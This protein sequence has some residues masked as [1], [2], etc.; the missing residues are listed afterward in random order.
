MKTKQA[1][2]RK[3]FETTE[4]L[5]KGGLRPSERPGG[6]LWSQQNWCLLGGTAGL[7][8]PASLVTEHG[9]MTEFSPLSVSGSDATLTGTNTMLRLLGKAKPDHPTEV[10]AHQPGA[11]HYCPT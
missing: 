1:N 5:G 9:H 10:T 3:V 11:S 4:G 7:H 8:F 6:R 2:V